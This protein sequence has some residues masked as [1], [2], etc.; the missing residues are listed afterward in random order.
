VPTFHS[1]AGIAAG[2]FDPHHA[3]RTN[4]T[5][6]GAAMFDT[7]EFVDDYVAMWNEPDR[8]VRSK[9]IRELWAEDGTQM[10]EAP[11]EMREAARALGFP[12][13]I[14][15]VTGYDELDTRVATA[16]ESFVAPGTYAFR[17]QG[18]AARLRDIVKF[19]WEMVSKADGQVAAVGLDVFELDAHGRIKVNHQFVE[20]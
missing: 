7:A 4:N 1:L 19:N 11:E 3:R 20:R 5:K 15:Q 10:I 17:S 18:N 6:I 2:T 16:Y 8:D 13:P 12:S 14:L 9:L